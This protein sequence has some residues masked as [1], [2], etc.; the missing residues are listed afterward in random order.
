MAEEVGDTKPMALEFIERVADGDIPL[1][2][3]E[4][5]ELAAIEDDRDIERAAV[6]ENEYTELTEFE[7]TELAVNEE[8]PEITAIEEDEDTE[9]ADTKVIELAAIEDEGVT[10]LVVIEDD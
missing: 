8:G 10:E 7:G 1:M 3:F 9:L 6:E 2:E 4:G 5:T